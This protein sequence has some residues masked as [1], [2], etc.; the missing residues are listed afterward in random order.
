MAVADD[1]FCTGPDYYD[2][3]PLH[4]MWALKGIS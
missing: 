1:V 3:S 4:K 2:I